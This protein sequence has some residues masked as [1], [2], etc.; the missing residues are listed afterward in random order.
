MAVAFKESVDGI[1]R[2][3]DNKDEIGESD[4]IEENVK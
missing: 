2:K 4:E 3:D 1:I